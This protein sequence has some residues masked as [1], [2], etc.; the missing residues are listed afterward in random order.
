MCCMAVKHRLYSLIIVDVHIF[1]TNA[2]AGAYDVFTRTLFIF[3]TVLE[4]FKDY[5]KVETLDGDNKYDA[6]ENGL[7]VSQNSRDP[8]T[9]PNV[10]I[11][12]K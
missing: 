8:L 5:I 9:Q 6:G 3:Y 7:Q 10:P 11:R 12:P 1:Q 4:S 2:F